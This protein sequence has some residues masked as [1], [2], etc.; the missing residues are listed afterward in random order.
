[1]SRDELLSKSLR[2]DFTPSQLEDFNSYRFNETDLNF[3]ISATKQAL[4]HVTPR[5]F[6]CALL[7]ALIVAHVR[8]NSN[9]PIALIGGDFKYR[10]ISL[11]KQNEDLNLKALRKSLIHEKFDGHFWVEAGGLIIDP[12]IFR[13]FYL[14]SQIRPELKNEIEL[15]FGMGKGCVLSTPEEMLSK[16]DFEYTPKY[17]LSE[18]TING[19]IKGFFEYRLKK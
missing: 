15:R 6:D 10:E 13:T 5:A 16:F 2:K 7:S 9:I 19:L 17:S 1:M 8:D 12:S 11:F 18:N 3:V 14:G 4:Y